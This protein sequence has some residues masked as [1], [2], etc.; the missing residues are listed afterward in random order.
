MQAAQNPKCFC[1]C[2]CGGVHWMWRC[3]EDNQWIMDFSSAAEEFNSCYIG[4]N[5]LIICILKCQIR[6]FFVLWKISVASSSG[7]TIAG[8][9][10]CS[11][12]TLVYLEPWFC[13]TLVQVF[14]SA[15]HQL[16]PSIC[17]Q[18]SQPMEN[19]VEELNWHFFVTATWVPLK[20]V[21][22]PGVFPAG[23]GELSS[24]RCQV[25]YYLLK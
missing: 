1:P 10:S 9:Q 25:W 18:S 8:R 22:A 13:E 6:F 15:Y 21:R 20:T 3:E 14:S 12:N 7:M 23:A 24:H 11:H 5:E 17:A 16:F 2:M 4:V 19:L